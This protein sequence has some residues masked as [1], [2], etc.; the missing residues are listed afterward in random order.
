VPCLTG[1][2]PPQLRLIIGRCFNQTAGWLPPD[3]GRTVVLNDLLICPRPPL[4]WLGPRLP[5]PACAIQRPPPAT[6]ELYPA[7][8][9]HDGEWPKITVVT[10]SY[11]QAAYLEETLRS[12]LDQKYPNLEYLVVDGGSTDGS[13]EI[14]R[15]YADR[16]AWWV[17]EKDAGQS[18][19]LNKG[20]ARATG[21][22]LTWLNSDDRL[23]PGS[24]YTVGQMFLM[25]DTDLVAGRCARVAD[26]AA[27]PHH[28]HRSVLTL[29]RIQPLPLAPLLD[30]DGCWLAGWFF[31]QPEVFFRRELFQRVGGA[32][33]EDLCYSM[34]YDLWVRFARAGARILAVPEILALFREH[35]RQKT[36]GPDLPYLPELR[37][38]NA[39]H[40]ATP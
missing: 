4:A 13:V 12:V 2:L 3:T 39:A 1:R 16:L 11:N 24:L 29:G 25:H 38:V 32:L 17:S 33:R 8:T 26:R 31:H 19:A 27:Q 21:D 7:A 9:A 6:L 15:R 5:A 34:D 30:L 23:A 28:L 22:I 40:R 18:Q 10:V 20:F 35:A 36:S 37:A 14:I